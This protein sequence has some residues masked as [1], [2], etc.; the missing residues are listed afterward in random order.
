MVMVDITGGSV[1]GTGKYKWSDT[2]VLNQS[3]AFIAWRNITINAFKMAKFETTFALWSEVKIWALNHGYTF[4]AVS[5]WEGHQEPGA[6]LT[7]TSNGTDKASR[8]VTYVSWRDA[9]VWCN[10][11]S[12]M[13]GKTPVYRDASDAVLKNST[14]ENVKDAT[15]K[16]GANGY[17]LPTEVEWEYAARGGVQSADTPWTFTYSGSNTIGDVAWYS[18][19][20]SSLGTNNDAYGAHPAG[21]KTV[22]NALGLFDMSGNVWEWCWDKTENVTA[23]DSLIGP[24]P[25]TGAVWGAN[26]VL[27][28]GSWLDPAPYCSV[29][30]RSYNTPAYRGSN[31]GFRVV[32]Q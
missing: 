17:R 25:V 32:C 7:G 9:V 3:G 5:G 29:T 24:T 28:G 12:E 4:T 14:I 1:T 18:V 19:N 15:M 13:S 27:R 16:S 2:N 26:R 10:A 20:S 23:S 8:P 22:A 6:T 21:T 31:L 30:Y 11:Y